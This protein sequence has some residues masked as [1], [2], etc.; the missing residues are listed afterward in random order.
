[1]KN[2][3]LVA[4]LDED[5]KLVLDK[6]GQLRALENGEILCSECGTPMALRNIQIIVPDKNGKMKYVCSNTE[7]VQS[8]TNK[9]P[10]RG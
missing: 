9:A 5:L 4:V 6:L 2:E 8:F 10:I 1:M 3:D 7:C